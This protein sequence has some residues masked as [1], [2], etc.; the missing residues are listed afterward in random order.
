VL[1]L[2]EMTFLWVVLLLAS[3]LSRVVVLIRRCARRL[4]WVIELIVVVIRV[5]YKINF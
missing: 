2:V 1:I 3:T 5:S 4:P